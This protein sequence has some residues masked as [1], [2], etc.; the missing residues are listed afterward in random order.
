MHSDT[1]E[2]T[3][4]ILSRALRSRVSHRSLYTERER[5]REG[6]TDR[7]DLCKAF[8]QGRFL[9]VGKGSN[10]SSFHKSVKTPLLQN[11]MEVQLPSRSGSKLIRTHCSISIWQIMSICGCLLYVPGRAQS[12]SVPRYWQVCVVP[13]CSSHCADWRLN[14]L[15]PGSFCLLNL[16]N[17][18]SVQ[19]A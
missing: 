3:N 9:R 13:Y 10:A 14:K 8:Y 19:Q 17:T 6:Q 1:H 5:E 16:R 4:T 11:F 2:Q 12:V 15:A 18:K 7:G